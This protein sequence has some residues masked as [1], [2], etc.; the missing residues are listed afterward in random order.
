M[1]NAGAPEA[2]VAAA[3]GAAE[4][5]PGAP[6][7]TTHGPAAEVLY[8]GAE[9]DVDMGIA[10]EAS[11]AT[12]AAGVRPPRPAE[13]GHDDESPAEVLEA[14]SSLEGGHAAAIGHPSGA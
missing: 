6:P 8:E 4:D 14:G 10:A 7:A 3:G 5:R 9:C 2:V 11:A 12:A 13:L 1:G